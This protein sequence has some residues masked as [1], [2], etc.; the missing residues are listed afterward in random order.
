MRGNMVGALSLA[1]PNTVGQMKQVASAFQVATSE[2]SE[3]SSDS[4]VSYRPS[5]INS[6]INRRL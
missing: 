2:T 6:I 3:M 5:E 4:A 1:Q